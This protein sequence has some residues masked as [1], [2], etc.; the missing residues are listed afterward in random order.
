MEVNKPS[1]APDALQPGVRECGLGV[2]SYVVL[3]GVFWAAARSLGVTRRLQGHEAGPFLAVSLMVGA[4][5]LF[6]WGG[7]DW[8]AV[9]LSSRPIARALIPAAFSVTVYLLMAAPLDSAS[10]MGLLAYGALPLAL[11]LLC[12][13]YPPG[14]RLSWQ[15]LIVLA[16]PVEYGWLHTPRAAGLGGFPKLLLTDIGLYLY[17][18]QRRLA[19]IGFDFRLRSRDLL[20]GLREWC[21]FAPI[22]IG[23][24]FAL[25]FLRF[26]ARVPAGGPLA[27]TV[28][29]TFLFVSVP[30]E[31]FFRGLLQNLLQT[32]LPRRRA[33]G[34]AAAVFGLSHYVHGPVF[35]WRYVILAAIAG[36]FYGRAWLRDRRVGASAVAHTLVDVVWVTWFLK[37]TAA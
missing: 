13:A 1:S 30:E 14:E 36:W 22:G 27:A 34:L 37:A 2:G 17:V 5:W 6:G 7:G 4:L 21:R 35:N 16:L 32:R 18:I 26:H 23:L 24:G 9:R 25:G 8:L 3:M 31:L 33:L 29:M 19:G 12:E 15:D 20:T 11:A 10:P 28:M